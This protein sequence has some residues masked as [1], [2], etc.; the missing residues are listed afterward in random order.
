MNTKKKS[1]LSSFYE[2]H[3]QTGNRLRQTFMEEVRANIFRAWIGLGK[4][5]LDLGGRDG[6]LTRHFVDGNDVLIGDVDLSAM[7]YAKTQ[8]GIA[9]QEVNLNE[10]LPFQDASFDMIVMAEV[11]E[12]LP[13][14]E[15]TLS[16]VQRVCKPGG[17]FLGSLPL[18]YHLKDRWQVLRGKKLWMAGDPTHLQFFT[19][20]ELLWL[21]SRF[22]QVDEVR[23]LKGG[24]KAELYPRL[25]ARDVAF[26]CTKPES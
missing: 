3:H 12:H 23:V 22:F 13:Y 18:A 7:A 14:P 26:K 20:D 6:T 19:Y 15:V 16:E 25:F 17:S 10:A 1:L 21:L 9:T 2:S 11:L 24:R 5:V 8:Y 4:R